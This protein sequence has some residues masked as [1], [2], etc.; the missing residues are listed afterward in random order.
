MIVVVRTSEIPWMVADSV[1]LGDCR[2]RPCDGSLASALGAGAMGSLTRLRR[3]NRV[4]RWVY[5]C[6]PGQ[7]V[8]IHLLA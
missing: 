8:Q 4:P 2:Q 7:E 1:D 5:L 3:G 6:T